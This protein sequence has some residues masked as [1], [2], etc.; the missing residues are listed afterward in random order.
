LDRFSFFF[1]FY[2]LIL[3]LAVTEL[4]SGFAEFARRRRLRD[5]E[6]Q[7]ALLALLV[8]VDICATWIDALL[9]A[10]ESHA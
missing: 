4:L 6:L 9:H 1:G 8:F 3:G 7:T 10:S 2:G 5:L